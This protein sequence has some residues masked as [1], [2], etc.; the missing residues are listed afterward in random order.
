MEEEDEDEEGEEGKKGE[1]REKEQAKELRYGE[2]EKEPMRRALRESA[3][4][5]EE[6]GDDDE[7]CEVCGDPHST[8]ED[9]IVF[10]DGATCGGIAV[11]KSCYCIKVSSWIKKPYLEQHASNSA[12]F[13][14]LN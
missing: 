5:E 4:E 8:T 10:C 6:E 11:H 9:P 12:L 14:F 2:E 7:V 13:Y 3:H 1:V